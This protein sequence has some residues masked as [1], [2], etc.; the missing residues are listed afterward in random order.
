VIIAPIIAPIEKK[1]AIVDPITE[2]DS[3]RAD[4]SF[5][6]DEHDLS[7]SAPDDRRGGDDQLG[8][9][10]ERLVPNLL[11]Q[12]A[13][14][15]GH[16]REHPL[17]RLDEPHLHG[18]GGLGPVDAPPDLLRDAP[19]PPPRERIERDLA[20]PTDPHEAEPG[21]RHVDLHEQGRQ[22]CHRHQRRL[23]SDDLADLDRVV[24]DRAGERRDDRELSQADPLDLHLGLS[25]TH[26]GVRRRD[27]RLEGAHSRLEVLEGGPRADLTLHE[28]ALPP[29]LH[30]DLREVRARRGRPGHRREDPRARRRDGRALV[31]GIELHEHLALGHELALVNQ[32]LRDPPR[33]LGADPRAVVRLDVPGRGQAGRRRRRGRLVDGRDPDLAL[34]DLGLEPRPG[35]RDPDSCTRKEQNRDAGP[36]IWPTTLGILV[37]LDLEG[38]EICAEV[39]H[40]AGVVFGPGSPSCKGTSWPYAG[41]SGSSDLAGDG[42]GP[43]EVTSGRS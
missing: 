18:H 12:E 43:W 3:L 15:R 20:R 29:R 17:D 42:R 28:D 21:L 39:A 27:L 33:R 30:P 34:E 25:G 35:G 31:G 41:A 22:I 13:H 4:R 32:H 8:G 11:G 19:E 26:L 9:R 5:F 38:R 24:E 23:R 10:P 1:T 7:P 16:V 2:A 14:A 36:H 37:S 6:H 40:D